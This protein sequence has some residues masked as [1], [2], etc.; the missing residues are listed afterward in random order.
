MFFK[1]KSIFLVLIP[2]ALLLVPVY[3]K[4]CNE[5]ASEYGT[6]NVL[7]PVE[8]VLGLHEHGAKPGRIASKGQQEG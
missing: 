8:P 2:T 7:H 5:H 1:K 3:Q 4:L 6:R